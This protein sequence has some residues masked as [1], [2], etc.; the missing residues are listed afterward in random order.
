V[1]GS[2]GNSRDKSLGPKYSLEAVE[3]DHRA[4]HGMVRIEAL[5]ILRVREFGQPLETSVAINASTQPT[6]RFRK[7]VRRDAGRTSSWI[8]VGTTEQKVAS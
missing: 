6:I 3:G 8:V 2:R 7:R 4:G 1:D 5:R